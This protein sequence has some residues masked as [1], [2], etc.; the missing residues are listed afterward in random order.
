MPG[1][2]A[3]TIGDDGRFIGC[4]EMI[5][6]DDG[7]A[8]GKS[9]RRSKRYAVE[10][11][12]GHRLVDRQHASDVAIATH[13]VKPTITHEIQDGRMIPKSAVLNIN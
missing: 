9:R 8:I 5:C 10:L 6:V 1:Y 2:R 7:E 13:K 3:Y 12:S 11:W 4:E